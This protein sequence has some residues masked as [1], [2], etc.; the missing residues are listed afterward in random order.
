MSM[1]NHNYLYERLPEYTRELTDIMFDVNS[2]GEEVKILQEFLK[3]VDETTLQPLKEYINEI[4]TLQD[5]DAI[6]DEL[7]PYFGFLYGYVWDEKLS[8]SIQRSLLKNIVQLYKRKGTPYSLYY[9]LYFHDNAIKLI[10]PHKY[11]WILNVR[12]K[13]SGIYKLPSED[14]YSRG[15]FVVE[16]SA[17]IPTVR[18]IIETVRPIGT[19]GIITSIDGNLVNLNP[20]CEGYNDIEIPSMGNI[21]EEFING[22]NHLQTRFGYYH[23]SSSFDLKLILSSYVPE[24]LY[25]YYVGYYTGELSSRKRLFATEHL[26][27]HDSVI[28][29]QQLLPTSAQFKLHELYSL[30]LID[31]INHEMEDFQLNDKDSLLNN[32]TY[33]VEKAKKYYM[34]TTQ[35]NF[36]QKAQVRTK[37]KLKGLFLNKVASLLGVNNWFNCDK[38]D[39]ED[40]NRIHWVLKDYCS[41]GKQIFASSNYTFE[42]LSS[43]TFNEMNSLPKKSTDVLENM[44]ITNIIHLES[45]EEKIM[46]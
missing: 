36:L 17:D 42:Q 18:D 19:V 34:M 10:E 31:P 26:S 4:I 46:N 28:M 5:I 6:R 40:Y 1:R 12:G 14:Y 27:I 3:S 41:M 38:A 24:D 39:P 29:G 11:I 32:K 9:Q 43:I 15:L 22:Q 35:R 44:N 33:L 7:L 16:T 25:A 37:G 45:S 30:N 21:F 20:L 13:L 23:D 2:S 8:V